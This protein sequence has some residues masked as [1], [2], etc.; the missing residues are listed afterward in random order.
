[1]SPQFTPRRSKFR[2][3]FPNQIREYRMR[4]GWTQRE[5]ARQVGCAK[6]TI[7]AWEQGLSL[8]NAVTAVQMAK[9]LGTLAESL[10]HA[11]YSPKPS[12]DDHDHSSSHPHEQS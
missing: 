10:Y 9:K 7:S 12:D 6:S 1:M 3:R 11:F 2:S 8:P 5:L 4:L